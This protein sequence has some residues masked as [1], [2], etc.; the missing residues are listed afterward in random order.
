MNNDQ[1]KLFEQVKAFL[2]KMIEV[3]GSDL[4][5]KAGS[6]IFARIKGDVHRLSNVKISR[7]MGMEICKIL[8]RGRT[9][10]FIENKEID[11]TFKLDENYRFRANAFFQLDG[12]SVVL[13]VIPAKIPSLAE[14]NMPQAL[15]KLTEKERGLVLVTGV[16]GSGKSTTLAA[17]INEI[18]QFKQKHIVTIED[19]IEFV[20][21]EKKCVIEQRSIGQDT[22]SFK[23]ALRGA[24]R[25]DPDIILIGEMRDV[26]TVEIALHA[27]ETGHL[28]F[29]TLHTLD[30]KETVNRIIGMFPSTEQN[31]IRLTL[32]DILEGVISQRLIRTIDDK[33]VAAMEILLKT[34]RISE[35]IKTNR[36]SE[37][38]DALEE[39]HEIYGTQTFDNALVELVLS[40]KIS[41]EEA[42]KNASIPDDLVLKIK[43]AQ[44]LNM[45][46]DE[47]EEEIIGLKIQ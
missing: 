16:T 14:L 39:G 30:A 2:Y 4:Y 13:R 7:E 41:K 20:H 45:A 28:V 36:D 35:L 22:L 31:R 1:I 27:A 32:A 26:E 40:G 3:G 17:M 11:F 33:R 38:K 43:K 42:I 44:L 29:S 6:Y 10:E 8:L 15:Y 19:P 21:K 24:L 12:P 47:K 46:S 23:N 34:A 5:I 25:E 37:I 18:N 9:K